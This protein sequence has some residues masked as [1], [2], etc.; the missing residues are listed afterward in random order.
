MVGVYPASSGGLASRVG[1]STQREYPAI[2]YPTNG[3]PTIGY[4]ANI[5]D[6]GE[7]GSKVQATRQMLSYLANGYPAVHTY[8]WRLHPPESAAQPTEVG[9]PTP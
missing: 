6:C 5:F 7:N 1:G 9:G 8:S 4:P 2:G 3:Y